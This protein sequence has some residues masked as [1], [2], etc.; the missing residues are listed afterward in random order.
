MKTNMAGRINTPT[1]N[2]ILVLGTNPSGANAAGS[3]FVGDMYSVR[4][5]NRALTNVEVEQNYNVDK[6]RFNIVD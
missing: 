3:Y 1:G 4:L 2:T 6:K 5:Y